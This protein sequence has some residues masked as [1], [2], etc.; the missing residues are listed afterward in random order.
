MLFSFSR[1][2]L[3]P[4]ALSDPNKNRSANSV[5][6][7]FFFAQLIYATLAAQAALVE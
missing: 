6:V 5:Q 3:H 7:T 1:S 2:D 4:T